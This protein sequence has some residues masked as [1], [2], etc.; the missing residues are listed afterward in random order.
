MLHS[1]KETRKCL[2]ISVLGAMLQKNNTILIANY[3]ILQF[4]ANSAKE[5]GSTSLS[6]LRDN[7]KMSRSQ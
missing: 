4:R 3:K 6:E 2:E 7:L 1:N 5:Y